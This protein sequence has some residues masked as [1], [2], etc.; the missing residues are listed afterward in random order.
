MR[1]SPDPSW[2]E[3][4]SGG[5]PT[6]EYFRI[7]LKELRAIAQSKDEPSNGNDL[8]QALCFIGLMSYFE[9]FCK[10][11]FASLINLEPRLISNLKTNNQNV[12]VDST[13]VVLYAEGITHRIG[14]VLAEKYDFGTA[15][16]INAFF[17]AL[18]NVTPFDT[19]EAANY[20]ELLRDR[21]LLVHHGG[22][23]T[24]SYLEQTS[25]FSCK[26]QEQAF[27]HSRAVQRRD[28]MSAIDFVEGIARKLIRA[29][30]R[31]LIEYL[32]K[33]DI[34]YVGERQKALDA[35]LWCGDSGL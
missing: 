18:L 7:I 17:R 24:L 9:A 29:S 1:N 26:L 4:F 6:C 33:E 15:Q 11:H 3:Y 20:G 32:L 14:F 34:H 10:D 23:F 27:V 25:S 21:N 12:D 2:L 19:D 13:R 30:H 31:A 16:K 28:V 5:V 22:T 8:L 35:L